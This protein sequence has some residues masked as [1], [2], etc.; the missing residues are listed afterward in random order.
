MSKELNSHKIKIIQQVLAC[1]DP[2]LL[3]LLEQILNLKTSSPASENI[4]SLLD[5]LP[6]STSSTEFSNQD[7]NELQ[8]S[9]NEV[10][11]SDSD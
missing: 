1:N 7:L 9:I 6:S 4:E 10:F 3:N 8:S 2:E 11:Q 5:A